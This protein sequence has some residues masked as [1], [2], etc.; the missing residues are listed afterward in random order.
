MVL[1]DAL[2]VSEKKV[3]NHCFMSYASYFSTLAK[4][5]HALDH[6]E[7]VDVLIRGL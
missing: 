3:K 6:G 7:L 5:C 4:S 1:I 2:G